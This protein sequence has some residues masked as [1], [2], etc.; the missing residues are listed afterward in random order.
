M[1]YAVFLSII[2][3]SLLSAPAS[4][5]KNNS[6]QALVKPGTFDFRLTAGIGGIENPLKQRDNISSPLLPEFS[7]YGDKFYVENL[8]LGYS[9]YE[10]EN[11][12]IDAYGYFN[13]DG[14]FFADSTSE[15]L[16]SIAGITQNTW[17]ASKV[18]INFQEIERDLSY[19]GGVNISHIG[20]W[21]RTNF[22]MAKDV[23]SVH[24]GE[25]ISLT[26]TKPLQWRSLTATIQTG[27][28]YKS[29]KINDYY[30]QLTDTENTILLRQISVGDTIS[31]WVNLNLRYH[32]NPNWSLGLSL[33][34]TW[35][36]SKMKSSVLLDKTRYHT[37]F[38][39]VSYRY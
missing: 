34:K 19:L 18:A 4:L 12:L 8:V 17:R 16:V 32:F 25:E 15:K 28:T 23:T 5:A 26:F 9:L 22:S 6:E 33:K 31:P 20:P 27:A 13:N 3:A 38:V 37:G 29:S 39:G 10:S 30:Y 36:D 35:L 1:K 2:I 24:H 14:Y 11:W 21:L 7:Y